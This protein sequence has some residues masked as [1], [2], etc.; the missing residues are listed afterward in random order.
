MQ[1]S[2]QGHGLTLVVAHH[3]TV[4]NGCLD[5]PQHGH[6]GAWVLEGGVAVVR[7]VSQLEIGVVGFCG[8]NSFR[9]CHP[10]MTPTGAVPTLS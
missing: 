3:E 6:K 9:R 10:E 5:R 8:L 4:G 2:L 1:R 7:G